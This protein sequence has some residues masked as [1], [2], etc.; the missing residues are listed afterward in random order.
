MSYSAW[1]K[2]GGKRR[3]IQFRRV[4]AVSAKGKRGKEEERGGACRSLRCISHKKRGVYISW[5][6][7][8]KEELGG[9]VLVP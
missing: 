2:E 6:K 5:K 3:A 4:F 1:G 7:K 9:F 8:G